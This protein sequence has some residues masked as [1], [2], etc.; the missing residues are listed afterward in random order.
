MGMYSGIGSFAKTT[1]QNPRRFFNGGFV[2]PTFTLEQYTTFYNNSPELQ[3][4]YSS[5]EE[6]YNAYL[7]VSGGSNQ[8]SG[9]VVIG[10]PGNAPTNTTN[11]NTQSLPS[12]M[13]FDDNGN[14]VFAEGTT[15]RQFVDG[16][17]LL[18]LLGPGS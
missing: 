17:N 8:G 14:V 13:S 1:P 7:S 3:E 18:G 10:T 4:M 15:N 2:L 9:N 6:A 12:Y 11:T 16:L 5:A